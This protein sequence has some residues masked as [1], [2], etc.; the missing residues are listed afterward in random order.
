MECCFLFWVPKHIVSSFYFYK[1]S[2]SSV[3][4][5]G[6]FSNNFAISS[7]TP[8][9]ENNLLFNYHLPLNT[10]PKNQYPW[11]PL[12]SINDIYVYSILVKGSDRSMFASAWSLLASGQ[13]IR[14]NRGYTLRYYFNYQLDFGG[15][16]VLVISEYWGYD[17]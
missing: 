9:N 6:I 8:L 11:F 15:E 7:S 13:P 3:L 1:M 12:T 14:I 16:T 5:K 2:L 10:R 4:N 17:I